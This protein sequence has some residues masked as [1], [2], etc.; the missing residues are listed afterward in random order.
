ML[1]NVRR[2]VVTGLGWWT[3]FVKFMVMIHSTF[4]SII[5]FENVINH[6]YASVKNSRTKATYFVKELDLNYVPTF[7]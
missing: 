1:P 2:V 6:F 5:M 4:C 7:L 3:I